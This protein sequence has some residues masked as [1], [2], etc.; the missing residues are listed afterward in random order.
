MRPGILLLLSL[1]S[2]ALPAEARRRAVRFYDPP[3]QYVL[4]PL[5]TMPLPESGIDR[6]EIAVGIA[7]PNCAGWAVISP[8]EWIH[9]EASEAVAYIT[10]DPNESAEER[11]ATV[12]IAGELLEIVQSASSGGGPIS[13]PIALNLLQNGSF[14]TDLAGWGWFDR[15]PNGSGDASWSPVD[16]NG[17]PASGS[18]L[19][20]DRL[21]S[22]NGPAYQQL[23][24][25]NATPGQYDYGFAVRAES[26]TAVQ[27]VIAFLQF[28]GLDCTGTYPGYTA[29]TVIPPADGTWHRETW[30]ASLGTR[31]RSILIVIGS[32]ARQPGLQ[33]VWIDDVFVTPR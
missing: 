16:A 5:F 14:H 18:I 17:S 1:L 23:Q 24:C 29:R 28:T 30:T 27:G 33:P 19:L 22:E 3:C 31:Y 9:I 13:P 12:S 6:G 25:I 8:V 4:T 11:R 20:R 15:F 10:A 7:G 2:I 26:T 21:E 32:W